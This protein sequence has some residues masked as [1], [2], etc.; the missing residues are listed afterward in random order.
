MGTGDTGS[1]ACR[2][3]ATEA[4]VTTTPVSIV[5]NARLTGSFNSSTR[6]MTVTVSS[7]NVLC[8]TNVYNFASTADFVD[9]VQ[10]VPTIVLAT[11]Q[12]TTNAGFCGTSA[13]T[14]TYTYDSQRRLTRIALSTGGST[15][16][17][18]WDASRRPT[19]GMV[20]SGGTISNVYNDAART[21]TQTQVVSGATTVTTTTYDANGNIILSVVNDGQTTT[22]TITA[23][24]QVCK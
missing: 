12:T 6:Q 3:Y 5:Q 11:S 8:T 10:V 24:A 15:N 21:M 19:L 13:V 18:A 17:T 4:T 7:N 14:S 22:Y 16:Y 1:N 23:T 2:T 20:S 9:E